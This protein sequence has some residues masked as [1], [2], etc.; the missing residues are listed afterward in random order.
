MRR[1]SLFRAY[2]IAFTRGEMMADRAE[3]SLAIITQCHLP[4]RP[5]AKRRYD[6][7]MIIPTPRTT[8]FK[9]PRIFLAAFARLLPMLPCLGKAGFGRDAGGHDADDHRFDG[10]DAS[11]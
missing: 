5:E 3:K 11:I 4:A 2:F 6:A 7:P 8:V 9:K 10:A 1:L